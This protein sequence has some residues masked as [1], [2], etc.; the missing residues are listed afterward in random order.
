[1][2]CQGA[3]SVKQMFTD[4][5]KIAPNRKKA[6]DGICASQSHHAQNPSSDHE[7]GPNGLAHAADLTH[8]P[9]GG[10]DAHARVQQVIARKERRVKYIISNRK[11]YSY[12]PV[13]NYPAWAGRPYHGANPHDKHAHTSTRSGGEFDNDTSPWWGE[14]DELA[15]LADQILAEVQAIKDSVGLR[16]TGGPTIQ[17]SLVKYADNDTDPATPKVPEEH[18]NM[19]SDKLDEMNNVLGELADAM[20]QM[21]GLPPRPAAPVEPVAPA[22]PAEPA[23]PVDPALSPEHTHGGVEGGVNP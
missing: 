8:D 9:A 19:I 20:R 5:N 3:P 10:W 15:G 16:Y 6:S 22:D 23:A 2:A 12:Y 21:A 18:L 13:G 17:K 1:M 11:I 14:E 4:A 7:A